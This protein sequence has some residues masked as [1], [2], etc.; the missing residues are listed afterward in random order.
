MCEHMKVLWYIWYLKESEK[1]WH[2]RYYRRY[3]PNFPFI[4]LWDFLSYLYSTAVLD[5]RFC[6]PIICWIFA[7]T[8]NISIELTYAARHSGNWIIIIKCNKE[9]YSFWRFWSSKTVLDNGTWN[10]VRAV[11]IYLASNFK[12]LILKRRER[13]SQ[14]FRMIFCFCSW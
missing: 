5:V 12:N 3:Y 7:L 9:K 1:G 14:Q 8:F 4:S 11:V 13:A 2:K 10:I 6:A